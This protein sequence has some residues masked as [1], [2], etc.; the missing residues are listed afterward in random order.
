M[1][2]NFSGGMASQYRG[3]GL[4][5]RDV[6]N[7]NRPEKAGVAQ[8]GVIA[9]GIRSLIQ[10]SRDPDLYK[11]IAVCVPPACRKLEGVAAWV[12]NGVAAAFFTSL[13]RCYCIH[14]DTED[15]ADDILLLTGLPLTCQDQK[16][17]FCKTRG[18]ARNPGKN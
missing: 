7:R 18:R 8:T 1:G 11:A 5:G 15:D 12:M 13:V 2:Q 6:F 10:R 17:N 14:I 16:L 4:S 3:R 9:K